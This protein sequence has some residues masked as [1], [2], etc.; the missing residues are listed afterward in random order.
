MDGRVRIVHVIGALIAGGAE[1]VAVDLVKWIHGHGID[2]G[3]VALSPRRDV[4]GEAFMKE[5]S[6]AGIPV[7]SGPTVMIGVCTVSWYA[8]LLNSQRPTIVHLHTPNTELTHFLGTRLLIACLRPFAGKVFRTLHSMK[9]PRDRRWRMVYQANAAAVSIACGNAV[10]S[11]Y[12]TFIRGQMNVISNGV[13][14]AEEPRTVDSWKTARRR[15]GLDETKLHFLCIGRMG[16]ASMSAS[17]KGHDVLL[18]AWKRG[19]CGVYGGV[20]HLIGD[21][22]HR[23]RLERIAIGD[24][25][26]A[27]HGICADTHDWLH[28]ADIF[29]LASRWEGLPVAAIEAV[30]LGLPCIFSDIPPFRE[31]DPPNARWFEVDD[32]AGLAAQLRQGRFELQ[33]STVRE[34]EGFRDRHSVVRSARRYL[35][36]YQANDV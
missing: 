27:F 35:E 30:G 9:G 7:D 34:L 11:T 17:P 1:R 3:L 19:Q 18:S 26:I 29:V 8:A 24:P 12:A 6:V 10:A 21:G 22:E 31:L 5:L 36:L 4:V 15:L 20:L 25:S 32:V 23:G 2:V 14:F 16:G 13:D 33:A 28:A